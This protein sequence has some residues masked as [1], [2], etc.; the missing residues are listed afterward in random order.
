MWKKFN[1]ITLL[2]GIIFS[3]EVKAGPES[4][5][6]LSASEHRQGSAFVVN[7]LERKLEVWTIEDN[8]LKLLVST[9]VDIGKGQGIKLKRGDLKTPEGVYFLVGKKTPPEIPFSTYGDIAFTT[10]YP[11]YFDV[12][13]NKTGDGI[14]LHAVPDTMTLTRGSK[15]C[16]VVS[17]KSIKDLEK[18]VKLKHTSLIISDVQKSIPESERIV[19][20]E[21]I[22]K[23][24]EQWRLSWESQNINK[25]L[26]F[27]SEKFKGNKMNLKQWAIFKKSLSEKNKN[28]KIVLKDF[29][30]LRFR[31]QFVV[32]LSQSFKSD[33]FSDEGDKILYLSEEN[34]DLKIISEE[35]LKENL[36]LTPI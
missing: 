29:N 11:N 15:G 35:F 34:N 30:I 13:E 22:E 36:N 32:L 27:Y 3:Y 2:V 1:L 26:N 6:Q 8:K 19:L 24:I 16:V 33:A 7:K 23:F 14:W 17:N 28:T 31:N 25:Y 18:F 10:N 9:D 4:I 21:K 20:K 5:I 12:L